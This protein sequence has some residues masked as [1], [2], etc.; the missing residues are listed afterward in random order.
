MFIGMWDELKTNKKIGVMWPNDADGLAWADPKTGQPPLLKPAGYTFVDGGRFQDGTEDFTPQI[1]K[2]KAADCEI[3]SGVMIPP[4]FVNFWKQSYQQGFKPVAATV[5]KALLFPS[6]LEA[7]GDIG[8]GLTT[9]CWW[10]PCHPFKSSLTGQTC[11]E[12][13]DAVTSETGKQWT[14]PLLHYAVF[15]VVVDALKRTTNVD[16]KQVILDAI[17]A[18]D[19]ETIQG[20]INWSAGAPLNPVPNVCRTPLVGGQWVKGTD[21]PFD[22]LLV[23]RPRH[24][25]PSSTSRR[26][27]KSKPSST[28]NRADP[29][30]TPDVVPAHEEVAVMQGGE[31][32]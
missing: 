23:D 18:T 32:S 15:E 12:L 31:I 1:S 3:L 19:L 4:D 14:Q 25:A 20:H 26:T 27:A 7:L 16:D 24:G 13:A 8:Y 10:S 29:T 5:G 11:Q 17:K 30:R 28:E 22:L 21:Y 6:E 2:F 9:E